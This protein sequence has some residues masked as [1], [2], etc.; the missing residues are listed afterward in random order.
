MSAVAARPRQLASAAGPLAVSALEDEVQL[1]RENIKSAID[2][3]E[4]RHIGKDAP[5]LNAMAWF[6]IGLDGTK[7]LLKAAKPVLERL[8]PSLWVLKTASSVFAAEHA[9]HAKATNEKL[10]VH[11]RVVR[12]RYKKSI[13]QVERGFYGSEIGRAMGGKLAEMLTRPATRNSLLA[14]GKNPDDPVHLKHFARDVIELSKTIP[15]PVT[16]G[17]WAQ[18]GFGEVYD[19]IRTVFLASSLHQRGLS[20]IGRAVAGHVYVIDNHGVRSFPNL[21][22]AGKICLNRNYDW[23]RISGWFGAPDCWE[24]VQGRQIT[25]GKDFM[26]LI[27]NSWLYRIELKQVTQVMP[28]GLPLSINHVAIVPLPGAGEVEELPLARV[29]GP[30]LRGLEDG[31]ERLVSA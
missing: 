20:D 6:N 12:D 23:N 7:S 27:W 3:V 24:S 26:F 1:W 29:V 13:D 8:G 16:L 28:E 18:E 17:R 11:Y 5:W 15:D 25:S 21:G 2:G 9:A 4:F 19:K 10:S 31:Y 30:T 22:E 14:Q